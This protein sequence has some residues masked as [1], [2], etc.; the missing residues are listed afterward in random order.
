MRAGRDHCSTWRILL[1][2]SI[3]TTRQ[4]PDLVPVVAQGLWC[5]FLRS[6]GRPSEQ[7][8]D[9]VKHAAV[10]PGLPRTF[11]LLVDDVPT[12]TAGLAEHDLDERPDLTPWLAGLYV[13]PDQRGRGLAGRP[14]RTVEQ[15]CRIRGIPT[16]WLYTNTAKPIYDRA[17]WQAVELI[18]ITRSVSR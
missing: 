5:A 10:A 13:V 1:T 15:K 17:E 3:T 6:S 8:L 18:D 11:I 7:L 2:G 9:P 12:G 4:W 16:A 14:I